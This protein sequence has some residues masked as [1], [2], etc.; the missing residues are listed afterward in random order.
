[1]GVAVYEPQT[2]DIKVE[3]VLLDDHYSVATFI[4]EKCSPCTVVVPN[5]MANKLPFLK[6]VLGDD[7]QS[8]MSSF[9]TQVSDDDTR[10]TANTDEDEDE[11]MV[12]IEED[13][14]PGRPL[15]QGSDAGRRDEGL[16]GTE[17]ARTE[18]HREEVNSPAESRVAS[19]G[20]RNNTQLMDGVT[21][22]A[23]NESR[24]SNDVSEGNDGSSALQQ[25]FHTV[26][27]GASKPKTAKQVVSMISVLAMPAN[28]SGEERLAYLGHIFDEHEVCL[29]ATAVLLTYLLREQILLCTEAGDVCINSLKY[30]QLL[31]GMQ[32]S[33]ASLHALQIFHKDTHPA[34]RGAAKG[35]DWGLF[36]NIAMN[37]NSK[38]SI[39]LLR[40]WMKSP[41]TDVEEIQARLTLVE[42]FKSDE[43]IGVVKNLRDTLR[44]VK[45]VPGIIHR[46][47]DFSATFND[48]FHLYSTSKSFLI[49]LDTFKNLSQHFPELRNTKF[50]EEVN[51]IPLQ[52][53]RVLINYIESAIDFDESKAEKRL[54]VK[55]KFNAE[56]GKLIASLAV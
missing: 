24:R 25:S 11:D 19:Q 38:P 56:I 48:W 27:N 30:G 15:T 18:S 49:L 53:L 13:N 3:Q 17:S 20:P 43:N 37:L 45:H 35:K 40:S 28:L 34:G 5:F 22:S 32:I 39:R 29:L 7:A 55:D 12:D 44:S 52:D 42:T 4:K 21:Q 14:Q 9:N 16:G 47:Y 23:Q 2:A 36:G 8:I 54:F 33:S 1:M 31:S 41:L 26:P 51:G 50:Y 10:A 46:I 6:A